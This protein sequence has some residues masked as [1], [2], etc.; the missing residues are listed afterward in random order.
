MSKKLLISF[1][2]IFSINNIASEEW[3]EL[4]NEVWSCW[5]DTPSFSISP[6]GKYLAIQRSPREDVCDIEQDKIKGVEEEMTY[7]SLTFIDLETMQSRVF[8]DGI[9]EKSIYG[10]QWMS[11]ERFIYRPGL[12]NAKG[13]NMNALVTIAVNV[14]GSKRKI[15]GQQEMKGGQGSWTGMSVVDRLDS[16]PK[17]VIVSS[18]ERRAFRND[19]YKMNIFTGKKNLMAIGFVPKNAKGDR[20]YGTYRDQ[21]GYPIATLVD[22]SLDRVIYTYDKDSKEWSEHIRF[23]CQQPSFTPLAATDKGWL[24]TGSKFLPNGEL[25]EYNDTNALYLYDPE[26]REFS[27]KLYQDPNYDVGGFTGTCRNASGGAGVDYDTRK[28]LYVS[29]EAQEPVKVYFDDEIAEIYNGLD[30]VFP[31]EW[32]SVVTRDK[33]RNKMVIRVSSPSNPGDYYFY[34]RQASQ[35]IPLYTYAPW[36][37]RKIMAETIPVKYTARDGLVIP[38]YLTLTKKKTDK[39][40]MIVLPHGGPNTKQ[41]IGFDWWTQF[42][43]NKGYNVLKMDFRG[44]TGLGTNHYVLGNTQWGKTMQDDISDGVLWAVENG[45]ADKDRVCIAGASYGGYATMAGLTFTPDL[46]RCGINSVGVVN[47]KMLLENYTTKSSV[48]NSWEDEAKLE[49][50][51]L[52]DAEGKKYADETSPSLYVKNIKAPVLVLQGTNDRTVPP[53]HA[54]ELINKLEREGKTYMSMFQAYEGHCVKCRG[55]LA[56]LEY[57]D[58]QEEFLEKYLEN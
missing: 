56:T 22:E 44:S 43:A 37:D 21:E 35:L 58:I 20:V 52:S 25:E 10:F 15:I 30:A 18:N 17:H 38:A 42:F 54:R 24:V 32:V 47:Q 53:E 3:Y 48:F 2:L 50:G 6:N 19:F 1:L 8:S 16:D 45:Y 49:W 39:N 51:N 27:E 23:T 31:N 40:Y 29:Y 36:I 46:Y 4:P 14:D 7:Q 11:D 26:T 41:R 55:E 13:R 5:G 12:T 9:G 33:E 57:F 28:L 34:N